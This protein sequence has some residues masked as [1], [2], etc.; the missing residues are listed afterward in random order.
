LLA[1][2][3]L[4][5]AADAW[6]QNTSAISRDG[7]W[8][9]YELRDS[10]FVVSTRPQSRPKAIAAITPYTTIP[11]WAPTGGRLAFYRAASGSTQLWVYDLTAGTTVQVSRIDGG[12]APD[13]Y[14]RFTGYIGDPLIFSW[15][16]DARSIVFAHQVP[17]A[18]MA[19]S[20]IAQPPSLDSL[21]AAGQPLV[22]TLTTP[23]VWTLQGLTNVVG[24]HQLAKGRLTAIQDSTFRPRR[25]TQLFIV[26]VGSGV[27]RQLTTDTAGYFTPQWSPDGTRIL[28]MSVEGRSLLGFGP[29]ESN[30]YVL[31]VAS[32]RSTRITSGPTQKTLPRWSPD[33]KWIA[34]LGGHAFSRAGQG[35]YVVASDGSG[36]AEWL[37]R[38]VDRQVSLFQWSP[39]SRGVVVV[40]REGLWEPLARV[41]RE[42]HAMTPVSSTKALVATLAASAGGLIWS[43][44]TGPNGAVV[45]NALL[46]HQ[47]DPAVIAELFPAIAPG[48][49]RRQ[50]SLAWKDRRGDEIDGVVIY[51]HHYQPGHAYPTIVD[52]Y[53]SGSARRLTARDYFLLGITDDYLIFRPNHRAPHMWPNPMKS[54][55][56]DSAA[57][58]P[59][60]IE[61]MTDDVLSG[62]DTLIGR[63]LIDPNRMGLFGF[64]N[65]G[66]EGEQLLTR[67]N[68]F[69]CAILQ[70]PAISD[71][72]LA[73]FLSTDNPEVIRWMGGTAPWDD[74]AKY[75]SLVPLYSANRIA[76]PILL[77][78]GDDEGVVTLATVEMY[79]ALRFLEKSVSLLRYPG[80]GHGFIGAAQRDFENR[81]RTFFDSYLKS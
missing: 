60:G 49:A 41:D 38:G 70:S 12:I 59:D 35:V 79:N 56:Y 78:V 20:R 67:T 50:E 21:R 73:F 5:P 6:A 57:A 23:G 75:T 22:L 48:T 44:S 29:E 47:R 27:T 61:V 42:T 71:L 17:V 30:L 45:L 1:T 66:L 43:E 15:S 8:V 10:L 68:R 58:G 4:N 46:E 13:P 11:T 76:T 2:A 9:A 18:G 39:D 37:T 7:G 77:A 72:L 40:S 80:Q 74:P 54:A 52:A 3:T 26:D 36:T 24:G 28:A 53:G 16:P 51:P 55:Q 32:G 63:G 69:R 65:G 34:F 25:S 33:G 31:D 14:G 62:V 64:S 19:A 81:V